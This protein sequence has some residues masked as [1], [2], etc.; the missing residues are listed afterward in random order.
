MIEV[1][2]GLA[3][4]HV[5]DVF[6]TYMAFVQRHLGVV[7]NL[8]YRPAK[9]DFGTRYGR[10]EYGKKDA[11]MLERAMQVTG[12]EELR[13]QYAIVKKRYLELVAELTPLWK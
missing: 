7:L 3:R 13:Q 1:E 5:I 11:V 6:P 10:V 8:K 9:A 2:K 12:I 4:G